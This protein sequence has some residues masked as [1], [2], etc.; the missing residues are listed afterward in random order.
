MK[1]FEKPFAVQS[2]K[3]STRHRAT[4]R[5]TPIAAH[6]L[7]HISSGDV[8]AVLLGLLD[9]GIHHVWVAGVDVDPKG[10]RIQTS[11]CREGRGDLANVAKASC[12]IIVAARFQL[13][14]RSF[15]FDEAAIIGLAA[16]RLGPSLK[17]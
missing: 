8:L 15:N 14:C 11:G 13:F 10:D 1:T 9:D 6:E 7:A 4:P 17:P 12:R 3:H 2:W 16:A 5:P